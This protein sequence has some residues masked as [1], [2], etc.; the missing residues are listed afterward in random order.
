M[1]VDGELD[2]VHRRCVALDLGSGISHNNG[3]RNDGDCNHAI[4][5]IGHNTIICLRSPHGFRDKP[6]RSFRHHKQDDEEHQDDGRFSFHAAKIQQNRGITKFP[7]YFFTFLPFIIQ[8]SQPISGIASRHPSRISP[9][10]AWLPPPSARCLD[11]SWSR[12]C[13][14]SRP[15]APPVLRA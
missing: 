15:P 3:V 1:L 7:I 2:G 6:H 9:D 12:I 8:I 4:Y 5:A 10:C 13:R 11:G 14:H